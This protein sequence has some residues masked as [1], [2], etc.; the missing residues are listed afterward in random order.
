MGNEIGSAGIQYL[1]LNTSVY[2]IP[3]DPEG[4]AR[5]ADYPASLWE[6]EPEN[7]TIAPSGSLYEQLAC[8]VKSLTEKCDQPQSEH[9]YQPKAALALTCIEEIYTQALALRSPQQVAA[10]KDQAALTAD[11]LLDPEGNVLTLLSPDEQESIIEALMDS[12]VDKDSFRPREAFK[13]LALCWLSTDRNPQKLFEWLDTHLLKTGHL[14][15]KK[16]DYVSKD[17]LLA[18]ARDVK[19]MHK[20]C[21]TGTASITLI[22]DAKIFY[23]RLSKVLNIFARDLRLLEQNKANALAARAYSKSM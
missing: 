18:L 8:C 11:S 15:R 2:G 16:N 1:P 22:R 3:T 10:K 12:S 17:T 19:E 20:I 5:E 9:T 14:L 23:A 21:A 7:E 4:E 6:Q 13:V